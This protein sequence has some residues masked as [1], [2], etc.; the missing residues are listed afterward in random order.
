MSPTLQ[1]LKLAAT[2]LLR[3]V[4]TALRRALHGFDRLFGR[5]PLPRPDTA[6]AAHDAAAPTTGEAH[7]IELREA[8]EPSTAAP[9]LKAGRAL[10]PSAGE[11]VS[12]FFS[13]PEGDRHY[14][15]Y[16]PAPRGDHQPVPLLVML[17]GCTQDPDDFAIGTGMNELARE[18]GFFVLYPAQAVNANMS[19]CWNWFM[20]RH[21]R[22]D[23]G[24]PALLADMTRDVMER[25]TIDPSRVYVA[26]LSAGGAMAAILAQTYP[27]LYAAVGVHSGL[28]HGAAHDVPSAVAAMKEADVGHRR[29]PYQ[30]LLPVPGMV[31]RVPT[32][33]F[34]GDDD[35]TV[36]PLN[37]EQVIAACVGSEEPALDGAAQVRIEQGHTPAGLA[38]TRST[39]LHANGEALAEHWMVHGV[40]H[41][42]S[43]G[44]AGGSYTDARGPDASQEMLRFFLQ[45]PQHS[46]RRFEALQ[47][48]AG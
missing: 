8:V 38:Y 22:R 5:H 15:L 25:H 30:P 46:L 26:G 24:E 13:H 20:R 48:A 39:Y 7:E 44:H 2:R 40:G 9:R 43:G 23:S 18:R 32:I 33:V 1:H 42:W 10:A 28:A 21:Q 4:V 14:K 36:H 17:H 12:G 29:W 37:G 3:N 45:H 31:L 27:D 6:T 16:V 19:R 35:T 11:F 41:A 34:H 47:F